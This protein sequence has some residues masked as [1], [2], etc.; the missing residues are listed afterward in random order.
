ML[1]YEPAHRR[2]CRFVQTLV[3]NADDAKDI[4]SETS[5]AAYEQFDALRQP[6]RFIYYLFAIASRLV[7]KKQRRKKF[8]G[9]FSDD[10]AETIASGQYADI[11]LLKKEL[12]QALS[13]LNEKQ[14][15]SV[16]L[17]EISGFSIKEIAQMHGLSQSGVKSNLKRGKEKL[18]QL[19]TEKK[20]RE[21]H[22][23]ITQTQ[24]SMERRQYGK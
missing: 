15:E 16:V 21:S 3:W 10:Y 24:F 5:L 17:F 1:L 13:K 12:H 8:F 2:L 18:T 6:E 9:I 20:S 7:K 11:D 4:V 14:R 22:T 23:E 19:L